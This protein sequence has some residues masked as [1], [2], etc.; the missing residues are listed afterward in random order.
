MRAAESLIQLSKRR[1]ELLG[2]DE[3]KRLKI[4]EDEEFPFNKKDESDLFQVLQAMANQI[5]EGSAAKLGVRKSIE[6]TEVEIEV[7]SGGMVNLAPNCPSLAKAG[8]NEETEVLTLQTRAGK[9]IEFI[10]VPEVIFLGLIESRSQ[11]SFYIRNIKGKYT[12]QEVGEVK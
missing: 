11:S 12:A 2:L 10:D 4:G 8:Y 3:P 7:A 5:P 1:S 6:C 9:L